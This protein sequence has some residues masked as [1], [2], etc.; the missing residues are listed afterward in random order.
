MKT[1]AHDPLGA[2]GD[3]TRRAV[4]ELVAARPRPVG[5]LADALPV[6]RPAVS[7]HLRILKDARLVVDVHDGTK[8]IYQLDPRGLGE[9]VT[10]L[11]TFWGVALASFKQ[12]VEQRAKEEQ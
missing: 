9:L 5:E 7:Q 11:N 6:S 1:Y 3:S 12:V 10:Y 4:F 2:L 8:R